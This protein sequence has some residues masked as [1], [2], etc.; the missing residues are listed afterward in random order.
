LNLPMDREWI[1]GWNKYSEDRYCGLVL[2]T[3]G[4]GFGWDNSSG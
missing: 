1:A 4:R 2:F 3:T